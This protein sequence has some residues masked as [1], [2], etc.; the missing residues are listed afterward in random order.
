MWLLGYLGTLGKLEGSTVDISIPN[1][2]SR[3]LFIKAVKRVPLEILLFQTAVYIMV[4]IGVLS[5]Y[6]YPYGNPLNIFFILLKSVILIFG[7]WAIVIAI[8]RQKRSRNI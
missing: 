6:Y 2:L 4:I 8:L 1:W 3:V 7:I 5:Y